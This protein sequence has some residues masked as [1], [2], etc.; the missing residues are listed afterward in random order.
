MKGFNATDFKTH[1][2][3]RNVKMWGQS[4]LELMLY[5]ICLIEQYL[6]KLNPFVMSQRKEWSL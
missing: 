1:L 3:S 2:S 6:K 4:V 5:S